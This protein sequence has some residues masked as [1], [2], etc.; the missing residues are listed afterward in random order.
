MQAIALKP[1]T[2]DVGIIERPEPQIEADNDIKLRILEVGICG[3][4]REEVAGGRAQASPGDEHLVLGHEMLGEVVSIGDRVTRVQKGDL[5][6]FTVRR[7]C[8]TCLPCTMNRSD[9]CTT[10]S[11]RERGIWGQDGFQCQFVVDTE[12][13][14]V[15]VPANLRHIGVLA[16]PLSVVEKAI[17]QVTR[18]QQAR[19]PDGNAAANWLSGRHCLVAGLGPIGLLAALVLRLRGAIVFGMDVVDAKSARPAWLVELDGTYINGKSVPLDQVGKR[20]GLMDIIVEATG[21]PTMGFN[22]LQALNHNG[23]YVLAGIPDGS[24]EMYQLPASLLIHQL[25]LN[26]QVMVGSVNAAR[27]YFDMAVADLTVAELKWQGLL[28][29]LITHRYKPAEYMHALGR[30]EIDDIKV[31]VD[32]SM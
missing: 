3:T 8:G 9:M 29:K 28:G 25:V 6:L 27:T 13:F 19:L 7:P 23:G 17:N 16:E 30:P 24:P 5:A 12:E 10:G 21:I 2:T 11:Y 26:N 32:W 18:I 14:V 4:D 1:G 22:L 20:Y 31:V 15:K